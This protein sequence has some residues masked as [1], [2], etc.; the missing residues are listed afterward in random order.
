MGKNEEITG[1]E[2]G[3]VKSA[4]KRRRREMQRMRGGGGGEAGGRAGNAKFQVVTHV[5]AMLQYYM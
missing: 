1:R 2:G 3:G 4:K 5:L